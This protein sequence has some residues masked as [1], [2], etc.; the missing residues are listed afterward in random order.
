MDANH[1]SSMAILLQDILRK[2]VHRRKVQADTTRQD[3]KVGL[4]FVLLSVEV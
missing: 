2:V 4:K 1:S 3:H